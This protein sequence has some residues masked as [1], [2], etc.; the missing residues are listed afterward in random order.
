MIHFNI[1]LRNPWV[2]QDFKTLFYKDKLFPDRK[3]GE[4]Q[5]SYY[6][7][8]LFEFNFDLSF[9]CDHAGLTVAVGVFG[10]SLNMMFYDTRHWDDDK[11][12][13]YEYN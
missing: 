4:I 6:R 8:S 12:K 1:M 5:L 3:A 9:N 13:W 11:G 7:H 2:K 10:L